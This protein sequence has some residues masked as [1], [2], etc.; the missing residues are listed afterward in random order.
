MP[1][2]SSL[3]IT[4]VVAFNRKRSGRSH[5][6]D[7]RPLDYRRNFDR[8]SG[9]AAAPPTYLENVA[10]RR[11]SS[12]GSAAHLPWLLVLQERSSDS[13]TGRRAVRHRKQ[14]FAPRYR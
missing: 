5:G 9:R 13:T 10:R 12:I 3:S 8:K 11:G 7:D 4:F 2:L 6:S 14:T 1:V